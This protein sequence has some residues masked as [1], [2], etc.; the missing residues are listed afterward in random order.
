MNLFIR[1]VRKST[2]SVITVPSTGDRQS[3]MDLALYIVAHTPGFSVENRYWT[4]EQL[5]EEGIEV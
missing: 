2:G 1:F 4:R 5:K 3:D